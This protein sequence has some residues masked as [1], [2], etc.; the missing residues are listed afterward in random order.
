MDRR[1]RDSTL[2]SICRRFRGRRHLGLSTVYGIV[3]Q[4]GGHIWVY[5]E[6]GRGITFKV[7]L[8]QVD[9]AL[10]RDIAGTGVGGPAQGSET[11]LLVEDEEAVREL[12]REILV[13]S[14]YTV[15]EAAH[16]GEALLISARHTGPVHLLITDIVMPQM[17]GRSLAD[18]LAPTRPEMNVLYMSGYTENA[19]VHHGVLDPG[20][21]FLPKPFTPTSLAQR[22]RDILDAASSRAR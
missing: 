5:S 2:V 15:L 22:V 19:V 4:S 16:G 17:S 14:G 12:A 10:D 1:S 3:K 21:Q 9:E 8:P 11:V 13:G 7:Y 18:R 6:P 20:T